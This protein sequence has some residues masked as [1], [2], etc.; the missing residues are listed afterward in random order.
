LDCIELVAFNVEG[1]KFKWKMENLL[2]VEIV[3]TH[4]SVRSAILCICFLSV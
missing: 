4:C 2:T 1:V 3:I